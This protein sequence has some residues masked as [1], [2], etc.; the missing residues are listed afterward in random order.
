[1]TVKEKKHSLYS[2]SE[3]GKKVNNAIDYIRS[4]SIFSNERYKW[5][6]PLIVNVLEDNLDEDDIKSLVDS[7]LEKKT[8]RSKISRTRLDRAREKI[9]SQVQNQKS[10]I[11]KI[12]SI[13]NILNVGLLNL[14]EPIKLKDGLNVFYGKNGAGKSSIYLGLC[15]TLGKDKKVYSNISAED[16]ISTCKI[17]VED[18]AGELQELEWNSSVENAESKAMIFDS[19]ISNFIVDEDQINQFRMVHLKMEYFSFLYGLYQKVESVI[20]A[21]LSKNKDELNTTK[22]LLLEKVAF[23]FD[24]DLSEDEIKR[25]SF[26]EK[27]R[28]KLRESENL[29]KVLE[30]NNPESTLRN[31]KNALEK[32]ESVLSLFGEPDEA[33]EGNEPTLKLYFTKSYF[34]EVNKRMVNYNNIKKAFEGGGKNKIASLIP[35]DWINKETWKNFISNSVDFLSSLDKGEFTKYLNDICAYCHQ[36]LQTKQAKKLIKAYQELHEEYKEKLD[37]EALNLKEDSDLISGCI[38]KIENIPDINQKVEIEFANIGKE[39]KIKFDFDELKKILQS[40]KNL[41]DKFEKIEVIE[42]DIKQIKTFWNIYNDLSAEFKNQIDRLNKAILDKIKAI[43]KVREKSGPLYR[44]QALYTNKSSILKYLRLQKHKEILDTKTSDL[45]ALRQATSS[46]KTSFVEEAALKEFK[47]HLQNE[48]QKL[49]F[50][51][52]E[53]W[54]IKLSTREGVN[55]RV[56]NIGDRKLA[57][58]FSEGERKLHALSDFF[59][60]CELDEYQGVFIFDD[61]V[62]SLD[63]ENIEIVAGRILELIKNSSQVIVFTHNLY[64]LNSIINTQKEKITKVERIHNQINLVKEV[65]IG[66]TQELRDRLKKIDSKMST[67]SKKEP[68]KINEYDIRN[69]YDLMSGYLEDYVEKVYFKNVISRY[70]PN[71][72]M[73]TLGDLKDLDTSIIGDVLTLYERTS[74]RGARH[75]QPPE[76]K[77]PKYEELVNDVKELKNKFPVK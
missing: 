12:T 75:S 69:V 9:E 14:N 24:E 54:S 49:S 29:M 3:N 2:E 67:L 38:E 63:E 42:S 57:D 36:P 5:I 47:K 68:V 30:K 65:V 76:V 11:R 46:L 15:K 23:I 6:S 74:R 50:T 52:P 66:E 27:E 56:Y 7:H 4:S 34:T 20:D 22:E 32:I 60:Q 55:R 26:T 16:K 19:S 77:K 53:T 1:M 44:K 25:A 72:R 17:T 33:D 45:S 8:K 35:P 28:Q 18:S 43:D 39:G 21:E 41:I 10:P 59:T 64:F 73:L 37:K 62:N 51:P 70:R 71:I 40:Y 58:I 48:Y 61:P 13:D 31:I